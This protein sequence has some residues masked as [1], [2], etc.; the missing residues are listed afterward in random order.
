MHKLGLTSHLPKFKY[1]ATNTAQKQRGSRV[2]IELKVIVQ[3]PRIKVTND[4]YIYL[5][6]IDAIENKDKV[7][8]DAHNPYELI[9][10]YIEKH[11][12]DFGK[13]IGMA[14][15]NYSMEVLHRIGK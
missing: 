11:N 13:L 8:I 15:K 7:L 14:T 10:D 5:Q 2:H 9:N 4:N 6:V 3:K 12:L 1:I